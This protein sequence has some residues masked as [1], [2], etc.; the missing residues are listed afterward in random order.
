MFSIGE[1]LS[2]VRVTYSGIIALIISM[3]S[4]ITGTIFVIMVTRKLEPVDMGLWTLIGTTISYV[5]IVRPMI[6]YWSIRQ[7]S[8][9]EDVGKIYMKVSVK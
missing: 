6:T 7:L 8:R 5:I 4:V 3:T 1:I 2:E 9:G